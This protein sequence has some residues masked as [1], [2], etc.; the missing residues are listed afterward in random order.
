MRHTLK[1]SELLRGKFVFQEIFRNG[2]R[3]DG[4]LLHC[5]YIASDPRQPDGVQVT[6][7]FAVSRKIRHAVDRNRIRRLMRESYRLLKEILAVPSPQRARSVAVIVL[8]AP[9]PNGPLL[10]SFRDVFDDMRSILT[11]IA[12]NELS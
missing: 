3:T 1:K 11:T 4:K 10:P 7:G 9:S 8:F 6:V 2:R 12:G 5:Y